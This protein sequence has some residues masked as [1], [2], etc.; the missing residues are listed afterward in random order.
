MGNTFTKAT[1]KNYH[2][3]EAFKNSLEPLKPLQEKIEY[4]NGPGINSKYL[5][6]TCSF[7]T[8]KVQG[9]KLY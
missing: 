5:L 7:S 6:D 8:G 1:S 4:T 3:P 2:F 9:Y